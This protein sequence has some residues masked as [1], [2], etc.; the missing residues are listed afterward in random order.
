MGWPIIVIDSLHLSGPYKGVIFLAST[1]DAYDG[2]FPLVYGLFTF[3]NYE[4]WLWFL[5][6]LKMTISE[7]E[8][9]IISDIHQGIIHSVSEVFGSEFHA[10]CYHHVKENFNGLLTKLNTRG[11]KGKKKRHWRCLTKLHLLV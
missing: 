7:R 9:V 11:R 5:Q 3:E 8:V 6:K 2:L 4:D 1:Y 10:H